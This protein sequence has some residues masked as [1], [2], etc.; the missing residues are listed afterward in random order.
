MTLRI[1]K[2]RSHDEPSRCLS[3]LVAV[4]L[5]YPPSCSRL[6]LG[7]RIYRVSTLEQVATVH[8]SWVLHM[9]RPGPPK[10]LKSPADFGFIHTVRPEEP[11]S[12]SVRKAV[13]THVMRQFHKKSRERAGQIDI[14]INLIAPFCPEIIPINVTRFL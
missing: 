1:P 4:R 13:R 14:K 9:R 7:H 2:N 10:P 12:T 6:T 3:P 5:C 11:A 8:F